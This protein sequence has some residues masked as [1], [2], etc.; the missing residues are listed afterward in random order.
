GKYLKGWALRTLVVAVVALA[1]AFL[2]TPPMA[3]PF[4]GLTWPILITWAVNFGLS[5]AARSKPGSKRDFFRAF[6]FG[7]AIIGVFIGVVLVR[8][9]IS[10]GAFRAGEYRAMAGDV[11][12]RTWT[13][14]MTPVDAG[15]IRMVTKE[16][17]EWLG[18]QVLGEAANA[19][20]SRSKIGTYS[21]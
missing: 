12:T 19:I 13:E 18:S 2:W 3:G 11:E 21:I 16:Q 7:A 10:S 9:L 4:W 14:D 1:F 5:A 17:A 8:M 20:G 15:H 6:R